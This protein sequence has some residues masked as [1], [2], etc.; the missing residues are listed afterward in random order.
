MPR[1]RGALK[2]VTFYTVYFFNAQRKPMLIEKA[3][4]MKKKNVFIISSPK[5]NHW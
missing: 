3:K 5:D 2:T 4:K 1:A